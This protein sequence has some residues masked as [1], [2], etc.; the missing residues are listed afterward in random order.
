MPKGGMAPVR[1]FLITFSHISAFG[2][3][4]ARSALSSVNPAIFVFELWQVTQYLSSSAR[5]GAVLRRQRQAAVR[6]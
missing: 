5:C 3:T 2:G 6:R 4:L 1:S